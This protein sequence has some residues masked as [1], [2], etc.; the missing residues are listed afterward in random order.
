[1]AQRNITLDQ[2]EIQQLLTTNSG[3]AFKSCFR[4]A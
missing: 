4:K 3:D 1:M 2:K